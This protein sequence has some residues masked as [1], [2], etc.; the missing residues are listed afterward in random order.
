MGPHVL[1]SRRQ[2]RP[3]ALEHLPVAI[4][5]EGEEAIFSGS[6][7]VDHKNTSGVG[8][9]RNP[10]MVAIYTSAR[11]DDQNQALAYS[12]D[13]GRTW[14]KYAGNPVLDD[15][16]REF[17]DPKVFWHE[18]E[19]EWRMVAVKAVQHKVAI[20][21]SEDLKAWTHLSDF[22]PANADGGVWECPDLFPLEVDGKRHKTKWV[23]LVSLNPGGIAGGSGMQYFVG[24][25]DGTRSAPTTA[26]LHARGHAV[27]GLRRQTTA[28]DDDRRRVRRRAGAGNSGPQAVAGY[29]G[30]GLANSFHGPTSRTG[31]L[32]SPAFTITRPYLNFLV[33]GGNHP[34]DPTT[35]DAPPPAGAVFADFEGAS[36]GA[37]TATGDFAGTRP[38]RRRR[39]PGE[40]IVN[41][42]IALTRTATPTGADHLARVQDHQGLHQLPGRRRLPPLHPGPAGRRRRRRADD[43]RP[44]GRHA[45]LA[46]WSVGDVR[47]RGRG[48]RSSTR[49]PAAGAT[50]TPTTSSLG[51][52]G[53][54]APTRRRSTCSSTAR[55]CA[56]RR[57]GQRNARL[58]LLEPPRLRGR[59]AQIQVV[60]RNS[61]GWGHILA[62]NFAFADARRWRPNSASAGSTTARTTTPP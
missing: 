4:P 57:P 48:S 15:D 18:P 52:A 20:Y 39:P 40:R 22:G 47:A 3:R 29:P 8:T 46:N 51:P 36:Y 62:D 54:S 45:Q 53:Q 11:P 33:G 6:A 14:T 25:F 16:D 28:L 10:P 5:E 17:R 13:R 1:G 24:D 38:S 9:R 59:Q 50:S 19:R 56:P 55:S 58:G 30:S 37:W 41:T 23:L 26:V 27:R 49:T 32:T 31:T 21:R 43:H 2:P 60:D 42:F 12:T 7:V 34:H 35:V 44:R 61:G